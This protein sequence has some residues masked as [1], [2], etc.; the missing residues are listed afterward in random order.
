MYH[1]VNLHNIN[2]VDIVC[3]KITAPTVTYDVITI[4]ARDKDDNLIEIK[5]YGDNNINIPIQ[6]KTVIGE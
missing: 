2:N 3:K 4:N 5:I 1:N 6:I